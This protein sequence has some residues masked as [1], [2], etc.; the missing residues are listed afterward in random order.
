MRKLLF[1]FS[2]TGLA[3]TSVLTG[4]TSTDLN[5][6]TQ[7]NT[8]TTP[9]NYI[10]S[11]W[12][13][14]GRF[15]V[16]EHSV[17]LL[18][19]W[20]HIRAIEPGYDEAAEWGFATNS[21]KFFLRLKYTDDALIG[22]FYGDDDLDG[23]INGVELLLGYSA[24][25]ANGN[26]D[27]DLLT[28]RQELALG[29]DPNNNTD[30]VD[31]DADGV[32]DAIERLYGL[33]TSG[34]TDLDGDS[35]HDEW[36]LLNYLDPA[37]NDASDDPD[38]DNRTN[39]QEFT[40]GTNPWAFDTDGDTIPDDV[41]ITNSLD[42][43]IADRIRTRNNYTLQFSSDLED[44]ENQFVDRVSENGGF[45]V[46]DGSVIAAIDNSGLVYAVGDNSRGQFGLGSAAVGNVYTT[47]IA[48]G[49]S[50]IKSVAVGRGTIHAV[51]TAG[52][53]RAAGAQDL[54][55]L[56]NGLTT[57]ADVDMPVTL[58]GFTNV[59]SINARSEGE[60]YDAVVSGD[61]YVW[62]T[63][64]LDAFSNYYGDGSFTTAEPTPFGPL[65]GI[66]DAERLS[67]DYTDA[68]SSQAATVL[69]N[70]S[71][72]MWGTN[73]TG[74]LT[75]NSDNL[76][77]TSENSFETVSGLPAMEEVS[78]YYGSV[79]ALDRSG[80]LWTWGAFNGFSGSVNYTAQRTPA[81]AAT[82]VPV[83]ALSAANY[84]DFT[85]LNFKDSYGLFL[86]DD[87][88][89]RRFQWL[90]DS[91][92]YAT[93]GGDLGKFYVRPLDLPFRVIALTS[94]I[95]GA[96]LLSETGDL[97]KYSEVVGVAEVI[98]LE[99]IAIPNFFASTD[100]NGD[101]LS[102]ALERFL[103]LNPSSA[104]TNGDGITDFISVQLGLD[105]TAWDLDGDG[106]P[107]E[108]EIANGLDPNAQ[109]S[110]GDGMLDNEEFYLKDRL[111]NYILATEPNTSGPDIVLVEPSSATAL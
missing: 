45:T 20:N 36:E 91:D 86:G 55:R 98:E 89:V 67:S 33:S 59:S 63:N 52:T 6:G 76:Y 2:L 15:Y 87:G 49:F 25:T 18:S 70:G 46:N 11:W 111:N 29:L 72:L 31:G 66:S 78:L 3:S 61:I 10:F 23:I 109:D 110:D 28:D 44:D 26:T 99:E 8:S 93:A 24:I 50:G 97:Y 48:T 64:L 7:V 30:A 41:E 100:S 105:S 77:L 42:P 9:D 94:T 92:V 60:Y 4:Q 47:P 103:G 14:T 95:N 104:D 74:S 106:I 90:E 54:G 51:E 108:V 71:V 79:A 16:I 21:D 96:F 68:R 73:A 84:D 27:G 83:R 56:G 57:S 40:D 80:G 101:G 58:S 39:L 43:T 17:D 69:E 32:V 81:L 82:E 102:D 5:E 38:A 37:I 75:V 65:K 107:N 13:K 85:P 34:T 88:H 22:S 19:P 53:V 62:G 35:M 1:C 12:G